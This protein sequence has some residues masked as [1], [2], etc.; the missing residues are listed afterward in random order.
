MGNRYQL[1]GGQYSNHPR[2]LGSPG[3]FSASLTGLSPGQTYH[4]RVKAIGQGM[5]YG[6]DVA[7]TTDSYHTTLVTANQTLTA[8]TVSAVITLN[9]QYPLGVSS[10]VTGPIN[11]NLSSSSSS[12]R[13]DIDPS[14]PFGGSITSVTV[15]VSSNSTSF[16]YKDTLAGNPVITAS[17]T[18]IITNTLPETVLPADATQVRVETASNG[19][20]S[21]VPAQN[22]AIGSSIAVFSITWDPFNNYVGNSLA[23][24]SLVNKTGS[25]TDTD[26]VHSSDGKSAF[27]TGHQVGT[28]I[29]HAA[30]NG[31]TSVDSGVITVLAPVVSGGGSNGG[32]GGGGGAA[33]APQSPK[34]VTI[35]GMKGSADI[36]LDPFGRAQSEVQLATDDGNITFDIPK[37][38]LLRDATTAPLKNISATVLANPPS[39]PPQKSI[40]LAYVFGPDGAY[41]NPPITLT[42]PL[43]NK[44][45]PDGTVEGSVSLSYWDGSKWVTVDSKVD[46]VAG[47]LT[48]Q[49]SHFSQWAL[50]ATVIPPAKFSLSDLKLSSNTVDPGESITIQ[51]TVNNIGGSTG[52]C[53][54]ILKVNDEII[55]SQDVVLEA[56]GNQNITFTVSKDIPGEYIIDINGKTAK[57][58]AIEPIAEKTP[59]ISPLAVQPIDT[60]V[61]ANTP[62]QTTMPPTPITEKKQVTP[63]IW[64]IIG[65]IVVALVIAGAITWRQRRH[66]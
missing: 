30:I 61:M 47:T 64:P 45:L 31:L 37:N 59:E 12:G 35:S 11:I 10:N 56:G 23:T 3:S 26:L 9:T 6:N 38:T 14:G 43:N 44:T 24:W 39:P 42:I 1:H 32:G 4:Y 41:F 50:I 62:N 40:L 15:P 57:F 29:I 22:V 65:V 58:T 27:F 63:W 20:G 5:A 7:F 8:D 66:P 54:V 52:N 36:N 34:P 28:A 51:T 25:V 19:S 46:S 13:F 18:G 60:P 49:I 21:I 2:N 53:T 55:S 17:G 33:P 48:A 16:Y